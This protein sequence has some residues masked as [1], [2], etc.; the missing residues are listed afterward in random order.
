LTDL[1]KQMRTRV[2]LLRAEVFTGLHGLTD[3]YEQA[4]DILE[5]QQK[6]I[7]K[8]KG[9]IDEGLGWEDMIDDH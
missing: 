1:P 8:L 2:A 5:A 6:E 7:A 9:M 3:E 4:A